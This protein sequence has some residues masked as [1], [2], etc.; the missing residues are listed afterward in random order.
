ML[1]YAAPKIVAGFILILAFSP[2]GVQAQAQTIRIVVESANLH[3]RPD[4]ESQIISTVP[5][6]AVLELVLRKEDWYWV[7]LPPDQ[8]GMVIS[9][10]IRLP[11]AELR[12][13]KPAATPQPAPP[14]PKKQPTPTPPQYQPQL[15]PRPQKAFHVK[16]MGGM[17]LANLSFSDLSLGG[18]DVL[19]S[20]KQT[21]P[22]VL[23]GIG[24]SLGTTFGIE[25]DALYMRKGARFADDTTIEGVPVELDSNLHIDQLSFPV[26]L[27][28][29]FAPGSSPF[30][31][32]GGEVAL[33]LS[34][35]LD[36]TLTS[37]QLSQSDEEDVKDDLQSL[38]YGLVFGGG[39]EA[40]LGGI[41]L[42]V[43]GRY[44][45]GLQNILD[46]TDDPE[47]DEY[48]KTSMAVIAGYIKF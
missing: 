14:P 39:Y 29:K 8:N 48:I 21:L 4:A 2:P 16:L 37:G 26:L 7:K 35:K 32:A 44:H 31:L 30:L 23:G 10:Y 18:Q 27:K 45:L 25:V 40:A 17:G 13:E 36:Y 47:S 5:L 20:A 9:G 19:E 43:E 46:L 34:A 41:C 6:G 15:Y 33:V 12:G 3:L 24:L 1:K 42:G 11:D 28:M 38:D 22:A